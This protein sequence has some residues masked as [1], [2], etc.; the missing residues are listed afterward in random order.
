MT[1]FQNK[2]RIPSARAYWW[3]Y[4]NEA[5]YFVTICT[6]NRQFSFG[7]ISDE[8]MHL[9]L[10]GGL[11]EKYWYEIPKHFPFVKLHAFVVMPDHVHGIIEIANSP[12][13]EEMLHATSVTEDVNIKH[14]R[15]VTEN[16]K[17]MQA[18]IEAPLHAKMREMLHAMSV[19]ED[20]KNIQMAAISPK[21]GSLA[22]IIRSY[23]S[24]VSKEA[25]KI[26]LNFAWQTR[27]HDHI[28]RDDS[29]YYRISK[30]IID[31]PKNWKKK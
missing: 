5:L 3:D 9:S 19:T 18:D 30:Y 11:A 26:D 16:A 21:R 25:H 2:Y 27:F 31:N 24:A 22:S 20:A 1:K 14:A 17:N 4:S 10:I 28:I 15:S 29:A 6:K 23:K 8:I 12:N 7:L 13:P